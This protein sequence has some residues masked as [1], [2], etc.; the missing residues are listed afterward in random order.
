MADEIPTTTV[1]E[2][3]AGAERTA[4]LDRLGLAMEVRAGPFAPNAPVIPAMPE[5]DQSPLT[6]DIIPDNT[7][8]ATAPPPN[9]FDGPTLDNP[10]FG[11]IDVENAIDRTRRLAVESAI[12]VLNARQNAQAFEEAELIFAYKLRKGCRRFWGALRGAPEPPV[13][14]W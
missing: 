2:P 3:L 10:A 1:A 12:R 8:P 4:A 5:P 13:L 7:P 9:G 14:R 6:A 11:A